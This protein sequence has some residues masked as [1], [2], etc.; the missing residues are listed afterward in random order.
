MKDVTNKNKIRGKK[1]RI[2]KIFQL[3]DCLCGELSY[4]APELQP[5][6]ALS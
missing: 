1:Y 5:G 2:L 3:P 6:E 4:V